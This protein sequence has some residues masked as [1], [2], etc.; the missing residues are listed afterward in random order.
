MVRSERARSGEKMPE[1]E[2][3]SPLCPEDFDLI[4]WAQGHHREETVKSGFS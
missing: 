1:T 4:P 2:V 3:L